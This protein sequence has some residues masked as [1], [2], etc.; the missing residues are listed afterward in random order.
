[1]EGGTTLFLQKHTGGGF[2]VRMGCNDQ[3]PDLQMNDDT[4]DQHLDGETRDTLQTIALSIFTRHAVDLS[5]IQRA[6]GWTNAVWLADGLVLRL[7]TVRG[8][9]SLLRETRLAALFPPGVGYPTLVE[10]GTVAGFAWTLATRLPGRSLGAAWADLRWEERVSA[11]RGLWE[12][13]PAIMLLAGLYQLTP[14]KRRSMARCR[15]SQSLFLQG[16]ME[17][18]NRVGTLKQGL[19]LGI[20]CV[21]SCWSLILLM[22]AL[23]HNRLDWMLALGS[24]MTA[25]RFTPWGHR[26]AGGVCFGRMGSRMGAH[27]ACISRVSTPICV[28]LSAGERLKRGAGSSPMPCR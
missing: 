22:F 27:P 19:R 4:L 5:T 7:S 18:I 8:S 26:L 24:I 28:P 6:G 15:P 25:E 11:L 20:F 2:S 23:G 1:M 3:Q 12:R 14:F 17:K 21:G 9:E 10:N 16:G 13:A